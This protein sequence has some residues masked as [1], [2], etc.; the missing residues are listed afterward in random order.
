M[1]FFSPSVEH[2]WDRLRPN[3]AGL[4]LGSVFFVLALT[5]SLI[6]RNIFFQGAACGVSAATGY[7]MGVWLS[8]SWRTW[9]SAE[10]CG[11]PAVG[12]FRPGRPGGGGAWR[13]R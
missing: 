10:S 13:S 6:P 12:A 8:W 7:L 4:I 5:P 11:R 9:V 3:P 2:A 1:P